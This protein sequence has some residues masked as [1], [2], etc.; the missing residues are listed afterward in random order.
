M[1]NFTKFKRSDLLQLT[2]IRQ[3]ERKIGEQI[4]VW[5]DFDSFKNNYVILGVEESVGPQSN[6]GYA[7]AENGF[8]AFLNRFLNLQSNRFLNG[9]GILIYGV[10]NAK[11]VVSLEENR[12]IVGELDELL[13]SHL[14]LIYSKGCI[15]ILIGGGHNNAFPLISSFFNV[16]K[17]KLNVI[18]C[19]PHADFRLLEGRHSGNSFSYAKASGSLDYYKVIGLHHSYNSEEMLLRMEH[20]GCDFTFFDDY[21]QGKGC[22]LDD[23]KSFIEKNKLNSFGIELD[24][25][26]IK[27]MPSSAYSFSGITVEEARQYILFL[28]KQKNVAYLHLPEGAPINARE[29]VIVGKTLAYLVSDFIKSN[30]TNKTLF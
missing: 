4:K 17:V 6:F 11:S 10:F 20:E 24:M 25:D 18:N 26:S 23:V 19:D 13:I 29:E 2:S 30:T 22:L 15:P 3:G 12:N 16:N 7:G 9:E 21:L 8:R 1:V 5:N 14:N 27:G 28:G